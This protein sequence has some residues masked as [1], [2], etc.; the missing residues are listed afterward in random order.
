MSTTYDYLLDEIMTLKAFDAHTHLDA[1]HLS[2]RG[3]HDVLLYHMVVSD[4][5]SAGCPD[6]DRLSEEPTEDE[7]AMRLERAIPYIP[8]ICN[9][10][11]FWMTEMILRDLYDWD[12][13]ITLQ[14]W[15][16]LHETIRKRGNSRQ[17]GRSVMERANIAKS[18]TEF[19]RGRDGS[20]DDIFT[21]SLEWSFFTRSQWGIYDTALIELEH[22]WNHEEPCPPLPVSANRDELR[23]EKKIETIGHAEQAMD[24][25]FSRIPFDRV[26]TIAS[27]LSTH[28]HYRKT[29]REE[30]VKALSNRENAGD[31]ERDVYANYLLE[32][33]LMRFEAVHPEKVLQFSMAAEPLPYETISMM[34]SGTPL[35]IAQIIAAHPKI[36]FSFQIANMAVNQSFC[37]MARELPNLSLNGYWWQNFFPSYIERVLSERLD[38]VAI[39]KII[40]FFTDAYTMEWS[41]AKSKLIRRIT[42]K[43]LAERVDQGRYRR[44]DALSMASKLLAGTAQQ[45]FGVEAHEGY[46]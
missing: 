15:Q 27:H 42:A 34:H 11:G 43:V 40:G 10:S 19:W 44:E 39:N 23:F 21:Y 25:Y 33:F 2:A 3:L 14:N 12:E 30:M 6:G 22:A 36:R 31:W 26:M 46:R 8:R 38:M 41:Y 37:T 28:I 13:P 35:E 29:T 18:N 24:H 17:F 4:L 20:C 45:I 7:A 32:E 1:S 9:T 5:Y 16:H